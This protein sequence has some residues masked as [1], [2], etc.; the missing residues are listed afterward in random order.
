MRKDN[1]TIQL[2]IQL[3]GN[4]M[5]IYRTKIRDNKNKMAKENVCKRA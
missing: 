5:K 1:K 2:D 4:N 3:K